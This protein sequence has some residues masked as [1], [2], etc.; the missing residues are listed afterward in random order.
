MKGYFSQV[1]DEIIR[2]MNE[3]IMKNNEDEVRKKQLIENEK[4][5]E[6]EERHKI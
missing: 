4:I 3:K 1:K 5:R 6:I 2:S